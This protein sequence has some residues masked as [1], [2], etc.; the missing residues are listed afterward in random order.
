MSTEVGTTETRTNV[1]NLNEYFKRLSSD[2]KYMPVDAINTAII[3]IDQ[4]RVDGKTIYI[5]G[6]GGS[7]STASHF[8]CDLGKGTIQNGKPRFK[9]FCLNDNV[10][11]ITAWANDTDYGNIFAGQIKSFVKPDD[12]VIAISVGGDSPNVVKGI[13]EALNQGAYCISIVGS[14]GGQLKTLSDTTIVVPN[15]NTEQVE[16]LH[17]IVCHAIAVCLKRMD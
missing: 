2:L 17:L 15:D 8:T 11:I 1:L 4:T 7:A 13:K 6:N 3:S 9:V 5:M 10:P 14:K 12:V 16:D